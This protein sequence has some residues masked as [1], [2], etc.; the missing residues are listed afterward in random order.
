MKLYFQLYGLGST[1]SMT[2][3]RVPGRDMTTKLEEEA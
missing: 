1:S 2:L 3:D